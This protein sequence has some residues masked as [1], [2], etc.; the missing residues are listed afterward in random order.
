M[1]ADEPESGAM[2]G[3]TAACLHDCN[4]PAIFLALHNSGH[5]H[6][7]VINRHVPASDVYGGAQLH[8]LLSFFEHARVMAT[9]VTFA[10]A[11][12]LLITF[13]DAGVDGLMLGAGAMVDEHELAAC[14]VCSGVCAMKR[15]C[16]CSR[17]RTRSALSGTLAIRP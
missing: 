8:A 10:P 9:D 3:R 16:A 6:P 12:G 13:C 7:N 17:W 11:E 2:D 5:H 4:N 1:M 15:H 14:S